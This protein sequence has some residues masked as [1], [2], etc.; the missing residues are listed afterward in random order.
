MK[1]AHG[2]PAITPDVIDGESR[3]RYTG[4]M[5]AEDY[6]HELDGD[7]TLANSEHIHI[8][9]LHRGE[10]DAIHDLYAHLSPRSR[11]LRFFSMVP[12]L[13]DPVV[14]LLACVDYRR[15][16]SIVAEHDNGNGADIVGLGTFGAVDDGNVELGLVVRDDWQGRGLGTA[17][18]IRVLDAAEARG[19]HRFI[20][21]LQTGNPAIR[22]IV[23][24]VGEIVAT[25]LSGGV[26]EVAFVRRQ[27][28]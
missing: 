9:A 11:Y 28:L 12:R 18:A 3:E 21:H 13:P 19:F 14:R 16:L 25:S 8:R 2:P 6:P 24:H 10:T 23:G 20:A 7:V 1:R 17:L 26:S 4:F 22:R 27:P 15:R 5:E